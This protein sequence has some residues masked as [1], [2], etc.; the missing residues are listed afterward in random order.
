MEVKLWECS[1]SS[2]DILPLKLSLAHPNIASD[3]PAFLLVI[4]SRQL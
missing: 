1:F 3:T 2:K 4:T